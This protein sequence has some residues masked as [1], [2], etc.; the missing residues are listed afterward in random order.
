MSLYPYPRNRQRLRDVEP[1]RSDPR[2]YPPMQYER[3]G[4]LRRIQAVADFNREW[5]E[6][7]VPAMRRGR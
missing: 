1:A 4:Y 5:E 6:R 3:P 7:Y 2:T